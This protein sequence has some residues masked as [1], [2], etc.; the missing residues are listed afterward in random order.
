MI[1]ILYE[2][3]RKQGHIIKY[4]A[5]CIQYIYIELK[6][7]SVFCEVSLIAQIFDNLCR[8]SKKDALQ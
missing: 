1:F 7:D 6:R 2:I 8:Y 3:I 5:Y 4:N